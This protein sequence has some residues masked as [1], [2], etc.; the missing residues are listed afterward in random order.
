M[1]EN[2]EVQESNFCIGPQTGTFCSVDVS[3]SEVLMNLKNDSGTLIRSYTFYP[4]SS[5]LNNTTNDCF[6]SLIYIGPTNLATVFS[7]LTF[8]TLENYRIIYCYNCGNEIVVDSDQ[9]NDCP[10]CGESNANED[11]EYFYKNIIRR[12]KSNSSAQRLEL[13]DTIIKIGDYCEISSGYIDD[14]N[15]YNSNSLSVQ[16]IILS[17]AD[18][19]T[20]GTG[21]ITVSNGDVVEPGDVMMLGPSNDFDNQNAIEYVYVTSVDGDDVTISGVEWPYA[22]KYEYLSGDDI[23]VFRDLFLFN[24][25]EQDTIN[26]RAESEYVSDFGTLCRIN[27]FDGSLIEC[28][29]SGVYFSINTSRWNTA[30]SA[31]SFVHSVNMLTVDVDNNYLVIR[32]QNFNNIE[33]LS[34]SII[35]IYDIEFSGNTVYRLQDR[36]VKKFDDG[37]KVLTNWS[38]YNY[39]S[40]SLI[41]YAASVTVYA[42][43]NSV[44]LKNDTTS[45]TAVVRDQFGVGLINKNVNFYKTGDIDSYFTPVDGYGLTD[46]NGV[47]HID[48]TSGSFYNGVNEITVR[49]DGSSVDT[50][51]EYVWSKMYIESY[52]SC[53]GHGYVFQDKEFLSDGYVYCIASGVENYGYVYCPASN[54]PVGGIFSINEDHSLPYVRLA[55][56]LIPYLKNYSDEELEDL[57]SVGCVDTFIFQGNLYGDEFDGYVEQWDEYEGSHGLDQVIISRHLDD[58]NNKDTV[59]INQ[60]TFVIEAVPPLWS[61]KNNR[62]T[63]IWIKLRPFITSLNQSTLVFKIREVSYA[64]DTGWVDIASDGSVSIFD[65]GGGLFGIEFNW[66]NTWTF[67]HNAVVYVHIEVYDNAVIP[68][69]II[70]DYWFKIIPDYNKPYIVNE[71][72]DRGEEDVSVSTNIE[73]DIMDAGS[74]VDID[75]FE[76]FV[77]YRGINDYVVT[78][79]SGGYH[80][81]YDAINDFNYGDIVEISVLANDLSDYNNLLQDYWVFYCG[82]SVGPWFDL[83]NYLPGLCKRGVDKY[84]KSVSFQV[85]DVGSGVDSDSIVVH[86]GGKKRNVTIVPVIYRRS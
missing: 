30:Y 73:F 81:F 5:I 37:N 22:T 11:V 77:N 4:S 35:S 42:Q 86:I 85:Y 17:F 56:I 59:D 15:F 48:F 18:N 51:S 12:W 47:V 71:N 58:E 40:D 1:Y 3:G 65:A 69:L 62:N 50:G 24:S 21:E 68:N 79:V 8:Y 52:V 72:P 36:V 26:I 10:N 44:V 41:P 46:T 54:V 76:F 43:P 66:V 34:K 31:L 27:Y 29:S 39:C 45:L 83:N 16:N 9:Y 14:G 28:N 33:P 60:F 23:Y 55:Q 49:A 70:L 67:H 7:N 75:S 80:I 13:D 19:T 25:P 61:E 74:G 64:G 20:S 63:R 53:D 32:S 84:T 78:T 2:I 6:K 38:S 57:D 82:E